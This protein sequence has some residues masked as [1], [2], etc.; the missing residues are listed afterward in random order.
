M[1]TRTH[2]RIE[3]GVGLVH[4]AG[5]LRKQRHDDDDDGVSRTRWRGQIWTGS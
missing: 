4:F 5:Y 2:Q 3:R 1:Q